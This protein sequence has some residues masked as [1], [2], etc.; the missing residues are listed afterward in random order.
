MKIH[1]HLTRW[2]THSCRIVRIEW[3]WLPG[4]ALPSFVGLLR[5]G[6]QHLLLL[7]L[8]QLVGSSL[9]GMLQLST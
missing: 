3:Q 9:R 5:H 6:Q 4:D 7:L 1:V 8:L 2:F